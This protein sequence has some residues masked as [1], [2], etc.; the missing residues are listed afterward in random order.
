MTYFETL[1]HRS[2]LLWRRLF[3]A[4]KRNSDTPVDIDMRGKVPAGNRRTLPAKKSAPT[5]P[6]GEN[7]AEQ[8]PLPEKEHPAALPEQGTEHVLAGITAA[9]TAGKTAAME[10]LSGE[11]LR[12]DG[13]A[14][15]A[16]ASGERT[17]ATNAVGLLQKLRRAEQQGTAAVLP[18]RELPALP[19]RTDPQM[20]RPVDW[21]DYWEQDAR[22]YD[23]VQELM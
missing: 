15:A 2:V 17:G 8:V 11:H 3:S 23:G 16:A 22:R 14:K 12:Q 10:Q 21:S 4:V 19:Q 1:Q 7:S 6:A 20:D 13:A 5:T 9:V 18:A